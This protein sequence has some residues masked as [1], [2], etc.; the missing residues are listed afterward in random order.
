MHAASADALVTSEY[1]P[2]LHFAHVELDAAPSDEEYVPAT[3]GT[4]ADA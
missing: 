1:L 3:H 2:A 4:H